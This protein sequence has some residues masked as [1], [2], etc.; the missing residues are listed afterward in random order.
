[1]SV[2]TIAALFVSASTTYSLP[3]GL[4]SSICYAES[5]HSTL[6]LVTQDNGSPSYGICQIKYDTAALMG[7]KGTSKQLLTPKVNIKYA[8]KY[9][10][11]QLLRYQ[12]N[13]YKASLAY[14]AGS[15]RCGK[16]HF[17]WLK[18]TDSYSTLFGVGSKWLL[19]RS[20]QDYK[21]SVL[22]SL[23]GTKE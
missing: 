20:K 1:M 18:V 11:Y 22:A 6:E 5:R 14:N 3:P 21:S 10:K 15:Y 19:E 12:G 2:I 4:L 17:Y 8:A 7:F 23:P 16:N 9:L 13:V